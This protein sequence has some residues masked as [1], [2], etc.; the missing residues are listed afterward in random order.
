MCV[1]SVNF[2]L[3]GPVLF[4]SEQQPVCSGPLN[5]GAASLVHIHHA[6]KSKPECFA[7]TDNNCSQIWHDAEWCTFKTIHFTW[8][9]YVHYHVILQGTKL[10]QSSL[11]SRYS[12]QKLNVLDK[13]IKISAWNKLVQIN[14]HS[15]FFAK[16]TFL[17]Q[18]ALYSRLF[19]NH[20]ACAVQQWCQ[21]VLKR[22]MN[23]SNIHFNTVNKRVMYLEQTEDCF[24]LI[25]PLVFFANNNVK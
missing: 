2:C 19:T 20:Q 12:K 25:N 3:A 18:Y 4:I 16:Q 9:A 23:I 11:I 14:R 1:L 8:R 13:K 24:R 7:I 21:H 10:W 17:I 5:C 15:V 6:T 22:V